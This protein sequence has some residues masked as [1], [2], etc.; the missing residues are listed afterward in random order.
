[1]VSNGPSVERKEVATKE[2]NPPTTFL[3]YLV[4]TNLFSVVRFHKVVWGKHG[5]GSDTLANGVIVGGT[6]SGG[7][8]IYDAAK[9]LGNEDASISVIDK[10]TM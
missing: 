8:H 4:L 1:M 2:K 9:L 6:D 5:M 10:V 3:T 7:I